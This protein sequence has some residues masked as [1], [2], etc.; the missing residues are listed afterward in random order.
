MAEALV[1]ATLNFR[2]GTPYSEQFGDV[3]HNANGGIPKKRHVFLA[4]NGLPERWAGRE[5]FVIFETGFG[6]GLN[7]LVT[8][9]AWRRDPARCARLH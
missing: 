4:G 8:R 7:F 3:Y 2:E 6:P 5:R 9:E 1:P